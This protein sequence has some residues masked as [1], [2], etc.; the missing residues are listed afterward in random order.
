MRTAHARLGAAAL[1][2]VTAGLLG[3]VATAQ[4]A[5]PTVSVLAAS[6]VAAPRVVQLPVTIRLS[7]VTTTAVSVGYTQV[8]GTAL[9]GTDYTRVTGT[10]TIPAGARST[11]VNIPV[12]AVPF[13]L[14]GA[15][16]AFAV[17]LSAPVGATAG[18]L[19]APAVI[20]ADS[21]LAK[22]AGQFGRTV[23][24]SASRL[25]YITN[26][27]LNQ[28]EVLNVKTG[29]FGAPIPVGS[30]PFGLDL[31][32]DGK[33][34]YVCNSGGQNI[35][36]IDVATKKVVKTITTP[37]DPF[38]V[39]RAFSIAIANNGHAV[40][41]TTFAGSG[42][43]AHIYDLTLATGAM[44]VLPGA[45]INGLTTEATLLVSSSDHSTVAG[46][47][48]DDS[49][50]QFFTY[51]AATGTVKSGS[52]GGFLSDVALDR[53]GSVMLLNGVLVIDPP[54]ATLKGT[55]T[56][57]GGPAALS[58]SGL[59][60][61]RVEDGVIGRLNI[62]RFLRGGQIPAPDATGFGPFALR[63]SPDGR[64]LVAQTATGVT[65]ARL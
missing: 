23:V 48:G 52:V 33:Q 56:G 5:V 25:A 4:A 57:A 3:P 47:I 41:T 11:V 40:F 10:A 17:T 65:V 55:V 53:T 13:T 32:P 2:A 51:K 62:T 61:Y 38:T 50:G 6:V 44:T 1:V 9:A 60:G 37:S 64:I 7:A 8:D 19:S 20:H 16:K 27:S 39:E 24:D 49:G 45:G 28:V 46:V 43:G 54:S 30:S 58:P 31:T 21:Y 35:S 12:A 29:Q 42:Y 22:R 63:I 18:T 34:L 26:R 59:L 15:D 14:R 36:V